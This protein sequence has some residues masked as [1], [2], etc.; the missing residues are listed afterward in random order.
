MSVVMG[1]PV[2]DVE[3]VIVGIRVAFVLN[4]LVRIVLF[5]VVKVMLWFAKSVVL[6]IV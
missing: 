1:I 3:V 4:P 6:V 2:I 5:V